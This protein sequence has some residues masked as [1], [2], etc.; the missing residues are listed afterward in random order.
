[1]VDIKEILELSITKHGDIPLTTG[2]LLNIIKLAERHRDDME[3]SS[4]ER[5]GESCN[6][7]WGDRD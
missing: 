6:E 2:H 4:W 3:N 5:V 1:M 7:D